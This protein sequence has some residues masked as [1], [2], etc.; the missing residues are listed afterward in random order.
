MT[1]LAKN[2]PKL[3]PLAV[4]AMASPAASLATSQALAVTA[5]QA[6]M[7]DVMVAARALHRVAHVWVMQLSA[8]NAL[9]WSLHKMPCVVWLHKRTARC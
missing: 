1:D 4:V 8:P 2:V 3:H 7:A 9:L 6:A 5:N